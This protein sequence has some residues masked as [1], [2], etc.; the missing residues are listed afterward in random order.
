MVVD[1]DHIVEVAGLEIGMGCRQ[2]K[3]MLE[4]ML[5]VTLPVSIDLFVLAAST[6]AARR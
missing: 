1:V 6:W 2:Y 4:R 5:L 3:H